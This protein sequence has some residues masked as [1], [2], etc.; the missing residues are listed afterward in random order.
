MALLQRRWSGV[1]RR[2]VSVIVI[3]RSIASSYSIC[4]FE[5]AL[6]LAS[7]N[8]HRPVFGFP[9]QTANKLADDDDDLDWD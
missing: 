4:Q 8:E 3:R 2:E 5:G 6:T 7:E 9:S 1:L